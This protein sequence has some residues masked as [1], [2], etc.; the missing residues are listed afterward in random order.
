MRKNAPA[1]RF[2][3]LRA[4]TASPRVLPSIP[5]M[6]Q[7]LA[8]VLIGDGAYCA[9]VFGALNQLQPNAERVG[10]LLSV[11]HIFSLLIF[12]AFGVPATDY[13]NYNFGFPFINPEP[14]I[15]VGI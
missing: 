12:E 1:G 6:A 15:Q 10:K 4:I 9:L 2:Q 11:P 3:N 14:L 7:L 13:L 8:L 5:A